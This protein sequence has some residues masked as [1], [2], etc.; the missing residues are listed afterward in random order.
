MQIKKILC[1][2]FA[3]YLLNFGLLYATDSPPHEKPNSPG[4]FKE[5][6]HSMK[7]GFKAT[8]RGIKKGAKKTGRSFKNAGKAFKNEITK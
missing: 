5:A 2:S 1:F 7:E 4:E 3:F 6:G 8:G